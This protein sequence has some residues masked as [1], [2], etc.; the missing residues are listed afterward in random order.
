MSENK[1]AYRCYKNGHTWSV[2]EEPAAVERGEMWKSSKYVDYNTHFSPSLLNGIQGFV[3]VCA[4]K[5]WM[6]RL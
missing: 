4:H 1:S 5:K 6:K 2:T 3:Y